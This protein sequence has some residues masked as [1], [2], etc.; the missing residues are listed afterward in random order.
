M[1]EKK[2]S[3]FNIIDNIEFIYNE[4]NIEIIDKLNN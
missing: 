1:T 3:T 2:F 4:N